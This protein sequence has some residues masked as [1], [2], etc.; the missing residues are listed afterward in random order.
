MPQN[1]YLIGTMNIADR[2]I[3][4]LDT[5]LR[6]RFHFVP[7]RA[8]VEPVS[9]VLRS[10]L[11]ARHPSLV[12][13]ADVVDHANQRLA[14]PAM[15][16][17]PSHFMRETLDETWVRRAWKHSILPMLEDHFYGE[18]H[19]LDDFDLEK[20]RAEVKAPADEPIS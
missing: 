15:T 9:Q 14:D 8:E 2:S 10:Y 6:R 19:R 5:A 13:V 20:L 3:A 11:N 16:I 7:F 1:L 18:P 12:W 17:G 4:L